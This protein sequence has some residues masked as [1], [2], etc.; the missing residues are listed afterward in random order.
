MTL[1]WCLLCTPFLTWQTCPAYS[2]PGPSDCLPFTHLSFN[3][4]AFL[5]KGQMKEME[6]KALA[7]NHTMW[8]QV[9][10]LTEPTLTLMCHLG[11]KQEFLEDTFTKGI[12]NRTELRATTG[13]VEASG[14]RNNGKPF[15]LLGSKRQGE[16]TSG[17]EQETWKRGCLP[18]W[19]LHLLPERCQKREVAESLSP[20]MPW[21][22][23]GASDR[24]QPET[25]WR[26]LCWLLHWSQHLAGAGW[27]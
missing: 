3:K 10:S 6:G 16:E 11:T 7:L 21:S 22:P 20:A 19:G 24:T 1:L 23:A 18:P 2:P 17:G 13:V 5:W 9:P 25:R 14:T 27:K 4:S 26:K 15:P 12:S 8:F